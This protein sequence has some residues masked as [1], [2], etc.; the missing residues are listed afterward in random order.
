MNIK[1]AIFNISIF[2]IIAIYVDIYIQKLTK[3]EQMVLAL[4][5]VNELGMGNV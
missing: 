3:P 1:P 2:G 4:V 5:R